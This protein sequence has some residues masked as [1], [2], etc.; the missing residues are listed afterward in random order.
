MQFVFRLKRPTSYVRRGMSEIT[1]E[2][3][4]AF[5]EAHAKVSVA[6]EKISDRLADIV[7]NQ[8]KVLTSLTA[9]T[10]VT[11]VAQAVAI[12]TQSRIEAAT[13]EMNETLSTKL[14]GTLMEKINN[15]EIS[16]DIGFVKTFVGIFGIVALVAF[17]VLK[18]FFTPQSITKDQIRQMIQSESFDMSSRAEVKS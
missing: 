8:D 9:D 2:E 11:K 10:L 3:L 17:V 16:K 12:A 7:N 14:P 6:L 13:R 1:K 18:V 4:F 5:T 15:S